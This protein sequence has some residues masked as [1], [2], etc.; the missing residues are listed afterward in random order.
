MLTNFFALQFLGTSRGI[1]DLQN[2]LRSKFNKLNAGIRKRRAASVTEV[3]IGTPDPLEKLEEDTASNASSFYVPMP[4]KA[5][6]NNRKAKEYNRYQDSEEPL[7]L[8]SFHLVGRELREENNIPDVAELVI[9]RSSPRKPN[10]C[11]EIPR[12][13]R[14][15]RRLTSIKDTTPEESPAEAD[16]SDSSCRRSIANT[17]SSHSKSTSNIPTFSSSSCSTPAF[18]TRKNGN[19]RAVL[20]LVRTRLVYNVLCVVGI[21]LVKSANFINIY[22][23]MLFYV[24]RKAM[25]G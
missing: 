25:K 17:S 9:D 24:Y 13:P 10:I 15:P 6:N 8:P 5:S 20:T 1:A 21:V 7:S 22:L 3:N 4:Q 19:Q 2:A 12:I 18:S 16:K 23:L 14:I 11:D